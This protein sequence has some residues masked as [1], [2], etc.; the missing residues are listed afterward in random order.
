MGKS[1]TIEYKGLLTALNKLPSEI[2]K[3]SK[4]TI[5]EQLTKVQKRSALVHRYTTRSGLLDKAYRI[6]MDGFFGGT[7]I[8]DRTVSNAP[9]AHAI[10]SG[11]P[12]WPNYKPG[13]GFLY[14]AFNFYKPEIKV[15]MAN[16]AALATKKVGL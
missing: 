1:V 13:R 4:I 9:Y 3:Q 7:L 15:E 5:K 14:N 2:K 16:I 12:D 11:R 8:L 10:H 6:E